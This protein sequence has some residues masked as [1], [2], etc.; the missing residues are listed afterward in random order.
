[1]KGA[2]PGKRQV[3]TRRRL[4]IAAAAGI[5]AT[6]R[7]GAQPAPEL[8]APTGACDC[9]VHILDPVR[10]PFQAKR[11]YTPGPATVG[12][13]EAMHAALGVG[14]V[15]VV[16]NSV[17]GADNRCLVDALRQIGPG[18]RGV[19][20]IGPDTTTQDIEALDRAGVRGARI[21]LAVSNT[22]DPT[23]ASR[24]LAVEQRIPPS[25]HVHINAELPAL[26]AVAV[27]LGQM[28]APP[29]L[30][31]FA[32]ARAEMG[33]NQPGLAD[34][35]ALLHAKKV[36]VKLSGP[37]QISKAAAYQDVQAMARL[38]VE[39][40]PDQVIWGSDWPHT[41]GTNRPADQSLDVIEAFRQEDDR[42]NFDLLGQWIPDPAKRQLVL[43]D[44]PTRLYGFPP[45]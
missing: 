28:R 30:D 11:Q 43:V 37:Y 24:A 34:I 2:R 27:Q 44:T 15:V 41:G 6:R 31:H 45:V 33:P 10:F 35:L 23:A 1:M 5:A 9:H 17:Y 16:Q 12:Q 20:T 22:N 36:V 3:T 4:M 19:A 26:A 8:A 7:V 32:H 18:S 25:W 21:N 13:M 14:R 40:A 39:A 29:V 42:F 38:F